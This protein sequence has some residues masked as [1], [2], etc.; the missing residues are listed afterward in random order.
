MNTRAEERSTTFNHVSKVAHSPT[1]TQL[2]ILLLSSSALLAGNLP[3]QSQPTKLYSTTP[4]N[5][6]V[7]TT[8]HTGEQHPFTWFAYSP[9]P[10][11]N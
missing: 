6:Q 10:C 1:V 8:Q 5:L 9:L 11:P 3:H 7:A 4:L 2:A